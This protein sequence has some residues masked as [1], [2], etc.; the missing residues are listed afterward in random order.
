MRGGSPRR[1]PLAL[2][3]VA[4]V[5]LLAT[6]T[7]DGWTRPARIGALALTLAAMGASALLAWLV[8]RR[9]T[10]TIDQVKAS[11]SRISQGDYTQPIEIVRRDE[12]GDCSAPS[13]RCASGCARR[14]SPRTI[15]R[16]C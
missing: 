11:A 7:A 3:V 4:P 14:A 1:P 6:D 2:A 13:S 9:I 5:I 8:A 10:G 16:A 12:L 15:C